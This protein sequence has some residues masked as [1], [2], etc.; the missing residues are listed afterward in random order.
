VFQGIVVDALKDILTFVGD[1]SVQHM[2]DQLLEKEKSQFLPL[3]VLVHI[4]SANVPESSIM[5]QK[6]GVFAFD[7]PFLSFLLPFPPHT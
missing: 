4:L 3:E 6:S 2:I 7:V 5:R 1:R